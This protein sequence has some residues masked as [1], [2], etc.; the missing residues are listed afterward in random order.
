MNDKEL[1]KIIKNLIRECL[2]TVDDISKTKDMFQE[3]MKDKASWNLLL[4]T[5]R[6]ELNKKTLEDIP[7]NEF[8]AFKKIL[9]EEINNWK[10]ER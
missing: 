3:F 10:P 7:Q 1:R 4:Y 5:V 2:L 6:P 8:E 9:F